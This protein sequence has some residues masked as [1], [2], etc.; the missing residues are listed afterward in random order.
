MHRHFVSLSPVSPRC[1]GRLSAASLSFLSLHEFQAT[2][3][4]RG[5]TRSTS[6]HVYPRQSPRR[7][8][9]ILHDNF[10]SCEMK[11][12]IVLYEPKHRHEWSYECDN[13]TPNFIFSCFYLDSADLFDGFIVALN[14]WELEAL[15]CR[16]TNIPGSKSWPAT[17]CSY[18]RVSLLKR[19]YIFAAESQA[20]V[21]WEWST[22]KSDQLSWFGVY[23]KLVCKTRHTRKQGLDQARSCN[24]SEARNIKIVMGT[25]VWL[26]V[27]GLEHGF[28]FPIYWVHVIIPTDFQSIIFQRGRRKTT[29]LKVA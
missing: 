14:R 21:R 20:T 7:Y 11:C 1:Q 29:R 18:V 16:G 19:Y 27:D 23:A 5:F 26:L 22:L 15:G 6:H 17:R 9:M 25:W 13:M 28:Y 24:N 2:G 10:G 4:F 12:C 8:C 3:I